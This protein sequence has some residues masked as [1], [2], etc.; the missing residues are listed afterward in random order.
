MAPRREKD[1]RPR[2]DLKWPVIVRTAE[3]SMEGMMENASSTGL[4]IACASPLSP[5]ALCELTIEIP[6]GGQR[7]RAT[8]E[9]VWSRAG[10]PS[11]PTGMGV[12][13]VKISGTDRKRISD[14]VIHHLK[15][16]DVKP[17]DDTIE[18]VVDANHE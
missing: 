6:V 8:A 16:K 3:G 7:L 15:L 11:I 17:D 10:R 18:I 14:A 5:K 1:R 4:F 2:V 9:V 13:F 12:R